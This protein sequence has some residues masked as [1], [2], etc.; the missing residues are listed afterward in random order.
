MK[1][2]SKC[3]AGETLTEYSLL[4]ALLS[5][6]AIPGIMTLSGNMIR[7]MCVSSSAL[8][9]NTGTSAHAGGHSAGAYFDFQFD[10]GKTRCIVHTYEGGSST[11][12]TTLW[13]TF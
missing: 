3:E 8:F 12:Q 1:R 10:N 6:M 11:G 13:D 2:C 7:P 4:I 5:L 9:A